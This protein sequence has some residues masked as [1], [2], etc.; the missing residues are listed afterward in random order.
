MALIS[1]REVSL[2]FGG[3][4]LLEQVSFHVE[5][6]ERVC[7]L[8]RN[9]TGKSTLFKLIAGDIGPDDGEITRQ[10]GAHIARLPQRVPQDVHGKTFDI[11]IEGMGRRGDLLAAY[12]R[13]SAQM[14]HDAS[15]AALAQL[16]RLHHQ[17]DVEG[18]WQLHQEVDR[19]L[20][21][22]GL[23]A[24]AEFDTL[25]GGLKRRVLLARALVSQPDLL[26]LDE[27]TNHLDIASIE[28]LETYLLNRTNT[29]LFVTHDRSFVHRLATRV[30]ELDRGKLYDW[31]CDYDTFL[32]RKEETLDQ[33]SREWELFDKK[34]AQEETWIRQGTQARTTRNQGRVRA[35]ERMRTGRQNRRTRE[36]TVRMRV[37]DAARTGKLV[38]ESEHLRFGYGDR[39]VIAEC[40]ATVLSG[41]KVGIIGP[42]GSGKT[43]L[44]R[45][46]LGELAPQSGTL[47][48][49]THLQVAYFDQMRD[50][51]DPEGTV[52][53]NVN[54]GNPTL[55]INGRARHAVGYLRDFL[56]S[57]ERIQSRVRDLSGGERTR[58]ML[59]R[60]F[61]RP[62]NVLVMDEPT[63]DLDLET[64]ELLE[65]LLIDYS[66]TLLLVSHDRMLLNNV[67]SRTLAIDGKGRVNAYAGGYDDWLWQRPQPEET[68]ES[69]QGPSKPAPRPAAP[70]LRKLSYREKQ[71]LDELPGRIEALEA[72]QEKLYAAMAD[73]RLYQENGAQVTQI[74]ARFDEVASTL[75]AAYERWEELDALPQ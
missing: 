24:E 16:D 10:Q 69:Q 64:L 33:E 21:H 65:S 18:A 66:G 58:L 54:D 9:G 42:N 46:L 61:A 70:R 14:V 52:Q 12:N 38:L 53:D 7:L 34:L 27:P 47:R 57:P 37:Q 19:V 17:L 73:P 11:V 13:A 31:G 62:F 44:L 32:Q 71:E 4:L 26:L 74:Q 55:T 25:S 63:N 3:P 60:L 67:V 5:R 59:A 68:P 29:L 15:S 45:L 28:W 50:Q 41:D 49:G 22:L 23:D 43:T 8:G 30:I 35:L 75:E 2:S 6:G 72:E 20:S 56:F 40:T 1:A 39:D 36:D 51:L 48:H